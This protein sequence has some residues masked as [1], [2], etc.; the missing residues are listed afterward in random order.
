METG[1][2]RQRY[3]GR[4]SPEVLKT[5]RKASEN[6]RALRS[7]EQRR[8]ELVAMLAA[9]GMVREPATVAAV[10][11]ILDQAGVFRSGGVL[12]GTQAFSC[13]ANMLGVR[14]DGQSL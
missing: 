2:K 12:V 14:F 5:I 9:G 10:L 3:I 4:E 1:R 13:Y 7:D 6:R 8:R 11:R